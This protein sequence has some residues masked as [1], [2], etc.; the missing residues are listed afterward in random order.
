AL[1]GVVEV[2]LELYQT[3]KA[4]DILRGFV[5]TVATQRIYLT[6]RAAY[7]QRV[8]EF[9]E[10]RQIYQ[11]LLRKD[12]MDHAVRWS[13]AE[14]LS[15]YREYE[16]AK[17]EYAKIPAG[18]SQ[19]RRAAHGFARVLSAQRRFKEAI[20]LERRLLAED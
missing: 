8:G 6:T 10:A 11:D 13:Y 15:F 1:L 20:E 3:H 18:V 7:H 9:F 5:P 12:P 17:A 2:A 4:F 19:S 14:L 16:E